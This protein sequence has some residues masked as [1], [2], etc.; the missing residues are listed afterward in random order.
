MR[1]TGNRLIEMSA[2]ATAANQAKVAAAADEASS[3]LRVA[4]PSDDPSAWM[5][6]QRA[7]MHK[8]LNS[9]AGAALTA[10]RE[11]LD[12]VDSA[13]AA[14]GEVVSQVR[15]LTVQASSAGYSADDRAGL[16]TQ[17]RSLFTGAINSANVQGAD[18][19][20]LLAG[21][22]SLVAP[23]SAAGIYVGDASVRDVPA[24]ETALATSTLSG[25]VLTA[26]SGVDVLPLL[27]RV[28]TAMAA[29]DVPALQSLLGE[30]ETAVSQVSHS[31]S[32]T[33]GMMNVLDA[34]LA[35]TQDLDAHLTNEVARA[36]ESDVVTSATN[37]AKASQALEAS[38]AVTSHIVGL[39]D[40]RGS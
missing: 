31:R 21:T 23:F 9:S 12:L 24:N 33:G 20:Y 17:V 22:Q 10:G 38:R 14:I 6:A 29:N 28:A 40:P 1:V 35:A 37:L 30:L 34:S 26:S 11:R 4:K 19:E 2:T 16:A 39:L 3:G 8:A 18:G 36:V 15:T 25:D 32:R 27:D 7:T 5:A 13:L